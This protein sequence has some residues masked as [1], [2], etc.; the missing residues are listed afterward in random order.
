MNWRIIY[1]TF[2]VVLAFVA[3]SAVTIQGRMLDQAEK[4]KLEIERLVVS[5]HS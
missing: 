2:V 5:E 3:I 1:V 4:A